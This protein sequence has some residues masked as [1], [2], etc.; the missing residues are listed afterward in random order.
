MTTNKIWD[1]EI[2]YYEG[3]VF[4]RYRRQD[5][6]PS[7]ETYSIAPDT[8]FGRKGVGVFLHKKVIGSTDCPKKAEYMRNGLRQYFNS[9][10]IKVLKRNYQE[11][12][13]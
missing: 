8:Y 13:A 5:T 12:V 9:F 10:D 4:P 1:I 3:G 6:H 2:L 7:I 11:Q